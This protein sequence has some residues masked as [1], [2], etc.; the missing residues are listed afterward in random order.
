MMGWRGGS[1]AAN[2]AGG[3]QGYA[4]SMDDPSRDADSPLTPRDGAW[5]SAFGDALLSGEFEDAP[6]LEARAFVEDVRRKLLEGASAAM[7]AVPSDRLDGIADRLTAIEARLDR[8]E[9]GLGDSQRTTPI[10]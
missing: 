9:R 7:A 3:G 1:V 10:A 2:D 4:E 5:W 8:I 6:D